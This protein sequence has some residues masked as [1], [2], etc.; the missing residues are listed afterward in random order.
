MAGE[1]SSPAAA[2]EAIAAATRRADG[3]EQRRRGT[4]GSE[5][6]G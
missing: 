4:T 6:E 1:D 5:L 2:M 3:C